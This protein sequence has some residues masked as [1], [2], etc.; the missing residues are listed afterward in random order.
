[1]G[2]DGTSRVSDKSPTLH[3][4]PVFSTKTDDL[5]TKTITL[6]HQ[7]EE[8]DSIDSPGGS[9]FQRRNAKRGMN[10][11]PRP[12]ERSPPSPSKSERL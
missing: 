11:K 7:E 2:D 8:D 10:F 4:K 12:E 5:A 1:M 9:G 3:P 6:S